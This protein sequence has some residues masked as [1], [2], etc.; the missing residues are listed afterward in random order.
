MYPFVEFKSLTHDVGSMDTQVFGQETPC[1]VDSLW[2]SSMA[3]SDLLFNVFLLKNSES[4]Q[5][6]PLI[7]K[8]PFKSY[9]AAELIK[10]S[11]LYVEPGDLIYAFTDFSGTRLALT[12]SYRALMNPT[13][14]NQ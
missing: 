5:R 2:A 9:E 10:D 6:L 7:I 14:S 8:R 11:V 1:I 13:P 12:I 4:A 3:T